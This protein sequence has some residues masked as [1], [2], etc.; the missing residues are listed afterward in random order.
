[1]RPYF[2]SQRAQLYLDAAMKLIDT[3]HAY[4]C[5]ASKE[6]LDAA[7]KAG[8]EGEAELRPS[9][10]GPEPESRRASPALR[11]EAGQRRLKIPRERH[12]RRSTTRS[13]A[14]SSGSRT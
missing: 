9:R 12:D 11:R 7:R 8:G 2:Q 6:E 10:R 1:M 14:T 5:Y 3:G 4:P 13:A